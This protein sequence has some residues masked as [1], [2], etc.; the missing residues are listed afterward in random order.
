MNALDA[1]ILGIIQGITEFLPI[2]SSGHLVVAETLLGHNAEELKDFDIA[3]HVATL[4]AILIFFR[5]D[6]LNFKWWP[7]LILASVPAALVGLTLEDQIDELFRNPVSIA[8][9][10]IGVGLL[11]F[12]P[13]KHNDRPLTWKKALLM[14]VAQA[15][16]TIPGVS[17]SGATMFTGMQLGVKREEAAKFSFLMGSIA[18]AGAGLL[19]A[20]DTTELTI[21]TSTLA[22]AFV[23]AFISSLLSAKWLMTFLH[24]HSLKPFGI[25]R[26]VLG[27]LILVVALIAS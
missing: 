22:V 21:P 18:I 12:I 23:A 25:Y 7:W 1:L 14:G 4:L 10:L 17:R 9:M 2:S 11:F 6:I 24:K 13:Q 3:L 20:L 19:K 27:V 15:V 16:A 5:K 8:V 26:I